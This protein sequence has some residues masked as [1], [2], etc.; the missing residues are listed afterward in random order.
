MDRKGALTEIVSES[1]L[2]RPVASMSP[3]P[4]LIHSHSHVIHRMSRQRDSMECY[5]SVG[6][7]DL[8]AIIHSFT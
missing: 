5:A 3:F 2:F 4:S 8:G 6:A 7:S 1:K